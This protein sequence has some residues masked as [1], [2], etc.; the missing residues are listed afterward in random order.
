MSAREALIEEI[1]KQ[2]EPLLRELQRYLAYL[3]ERE[4]HSN[5]GSSPS[6]VSCWPKGYFE[7]TAG[8]FAGEPLERP[9]Q[10]PFEKREEW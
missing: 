6:M 8:A 9:P 10:L 3:V 5:H 1:L 2:P 4:K 7:R